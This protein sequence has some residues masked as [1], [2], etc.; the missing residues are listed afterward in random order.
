MTL[1][2]ELFSPSFLLCLG[3]I[4]V[5]TSVLVVYFEGKFREQN[6]KINAMFSIVTTLVEKVNEIKEGEE[7]AEEVKQIHIEPSSSHGGDLIE[8]SDDEIMEEEE[9]E[10]EDNDDDEEDEDEEEDEHDE[11]EEDKES[12]QCED[13]EDLQDIKEEEIIVSKLGSDIVE[14]L[15]DE[16]EDE[17]DHEV[18]QWLQQQNSHHK[19]EMQKQEQEK[20]QKEEKEYKKMSLPELRKLAV[21]QGLVFDASRLKK[22]E[23]IKL[24]FALEESER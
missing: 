4:L 24:F 11:E 15:P 10:E 5:V 14:L 22:P 8:V 23:L 21:S 9:D 13:I 1:F 16:Q 3:I 6:H 20:K 19:E 17:P 18:E 2:T 7:D 12:I